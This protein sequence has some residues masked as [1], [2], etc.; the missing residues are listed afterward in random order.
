MGDG[1]AV[2]AVA[3][4]RCPTGLQ[5]PAQGVAGCSFGKR[6]LDSVPSYCCT[7]A[8]CGCGDTRSPALVVGLCE[9]P[10][11]GS[12]VC[13]VQGYAQGTVGE[14]L[15]GEGRLG[16]PTSTVSA[17]LC[18]KDHPTGFLP[19]PASQYSSLK[20]VWRP[21]TA[22]SIVQN[23]RG[24]TRKRVFWGGKCQPLCCSGFE[25]LG[26]GGPAPPPSPL[27]PST[28]P[29][30]TRHQAARDLESAK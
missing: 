5:T 3:G 15:R 1:L 26:W 23:M 6:R 9:L 29:Q 12:C 7:A 24:A 25:A 19:G 8:T 2:P 22:P 14:W 21:S 11:F 10:P 28:L 17:F 4:W 20:G 27:P 18:V 16:Q 30:E 13:V